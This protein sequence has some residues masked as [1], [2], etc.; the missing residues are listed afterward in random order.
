MDTRTSP[1]EP[2]RLLRIQEAAIEVG[3]TP[4]SVRYYEEVGLLRPA[5]R[6]IGDYRL[7][8]DTDLERLRFI[9]GLRDDA[10]F[11]LAEIAQLLEDEA[12]RER[13]HEAYHATADPSERLQILRDR[14]TRYDHQ[15][16]MLRTKI[17]RLQ[18]MV[19]ETAGRR[20]QTVAKIDAESEATR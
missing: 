10:G 18:T 14:V 2:G 4:R 5:A 15:I 8:D 6:S 16:A 12:A 3:L 20:A 19:D 13:G 1:T 7:Y 11:S 17:D 9:K